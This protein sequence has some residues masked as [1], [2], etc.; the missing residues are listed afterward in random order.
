MTITEL[1][2]DLIDTSKERL[3]TPISG[4]FLITFIIYNWRPILFLIFSEASIE[5]KIIVINHEY[6]SL[7]AFLFPVFIALFYTLLIPKLMLKIDKSLI[8]TTEERIKN[9]YDSKGHAMSCK[10]ELAKKEFELK[11][12]ETG[13]KQIEE[14]LSQIN[15]LKESNTQITKANQIEVEQLNENLKKSNEQLKETLRDIENRRTLNP[16]SLSAIRENKKNQLSPHEHK[17][18][19]TNSLENTIIDLLNTLG[20]ND[21]NQFKKLRR[22]SDGEIEGGSLRSIKQETINHFILMG[23]ISPKE[24]QFYFTNNGEILYN[25]LRAN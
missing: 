7:W 24:N 3:K 15:N 6:C 19:E 9:I 16:L 5:D 17:Y 25:I 13:N 22:L 21:L 23:F 1:I 12:I 14:L 11:N 4:A 18:S 2:K 10:I 20:D 8:E